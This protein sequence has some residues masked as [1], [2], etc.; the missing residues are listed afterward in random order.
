MQDMGRMLPT[1]RVNEQSK[2]GAAQDLTSHG[3]RFS[4]DDRGKTIQE[5]VTFS[6]FGTHISFRKLGQKRMADEKK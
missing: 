1:N 3:R 4:L 2:T 5:S 6:A